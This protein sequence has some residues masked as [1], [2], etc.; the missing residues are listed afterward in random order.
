MPESS[1][2]DSLSRERETFLK[3]QISP[4]LTELLKRLVVVFV[5]VSA[6]LRSLRLMVRRGGP[7]KS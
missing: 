4:I 7:Q 1:M 5:A 2:T 6:R 3:S